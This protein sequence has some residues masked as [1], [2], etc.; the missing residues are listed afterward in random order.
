MDDNHLDLV[1]NEAKQIQ[2]VKLMTIYNSRVE[3]C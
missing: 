2:A 1:F 3:R